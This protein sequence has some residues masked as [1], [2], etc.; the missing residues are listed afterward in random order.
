MLLLSGCSFV[1]NP[2][3][4]DIVRP[5]RDQLLIVGQGGAGNAWI[6]RGILENIQ[7][8]D[9]VLVLW[10][11]F[12]RLD[13]EV[14]AEM[15]GD[16]KTYYDDNTTPY[17]YTK[18]K[19]SIWFH[20]GGWDGTWCNW[21]RTRYA[22]YMYKLM[23]SQYKSLNWDHHT[24]KNLIAIAGCLNTLEAK[25]IPYKYGFICDIF[26]DYGTIQGS[27][28][29]AVSR[30]NPLLDLLNKEHCLSSSPYDYC[31]EN[32]LLSGDRF[33]PSELGYNKWWNSVK[34]EV[35]FL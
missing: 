4:P 2:Y 19:S 28:G 24:D 23:Q 22:T 8:A 27:L 16:V 33:H 32:N 5:G 18:S 34:H 12:S 6:S 14:P 29:G 15:I 9:N 7:Q 20:S 21:T 11:G 10:S 3:M 25:G 31:S 1:D 30:D 13:I 26:K 17:H 35:P